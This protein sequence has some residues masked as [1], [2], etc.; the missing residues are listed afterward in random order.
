MAGDRKFESN[1]EVIDGVN[2]Y[3][4]ALVES[5]HKNGIIALEYHYEKYINLDGDYVEN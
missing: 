5:D 4:E 3:F 2:E 1:E